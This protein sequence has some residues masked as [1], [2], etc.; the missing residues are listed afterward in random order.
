MGSV[1]PNKHC[2]EIQRRQEM[3]AF[4]INGKIDQTSIAT[5]HQQKR[6]TAVFAHRCTKRSKTRGAQLRNAL[7]D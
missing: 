7:K 6:G 2:N 3:K 1:L 4:K 5:G